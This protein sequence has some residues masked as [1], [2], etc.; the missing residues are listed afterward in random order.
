MVYRV[1][2]KVQYPRWYF[3]HRPWI[4]SEPQEIIHGESKTNDKG[5]FEITFKAIPAQSVDKSSLPVFN[6]EIT[7][8][9]TDLNG[10]TRST[11]TIVNVGYRA[12][13]ANMSV[14]ET[15]NKIK[16]DHSISIDTKNLNGEFVSAKGTIKI[17][18]L[19]A[20]NIV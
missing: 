3:W 11:K 19:I 13:I 18:K 7:A 4:N 15:L 12:L 14:D 5:E 1:H 9:V 2:R 6:Y 20:P 10:E 16:K 17:Y 8:D